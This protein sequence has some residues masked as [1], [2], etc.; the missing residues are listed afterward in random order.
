MLPSVEM[1]AADTP[2]QFADHVQRHMANRMEVPVSDADAC[3]LEEWKAGEGLQHFHFASRNHH[4]LSDLKPNLQVFFLNAC[5]VVVFVGIF[6][7]NEVLV[8][9]SVA[10]CGSFPG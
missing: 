1:A 2:Q 4:I 8:G 5:I 7:K 10:K 3:A 6:L 9:I